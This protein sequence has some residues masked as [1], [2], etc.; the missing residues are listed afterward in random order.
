MT[1]KA[2][3]SIFKNT[4][5]KWTLVIFQAAHDL[6]IKIKMFRIYLIKNVKMQNPYVR[7]QLN[8]HLD[9]C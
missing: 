8:C 3:L 5:N 4:S 1:G 2:K 7:F 9:T 6:V